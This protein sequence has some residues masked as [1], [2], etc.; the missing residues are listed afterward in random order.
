MDSPPRLLLSLS[1]LR[2]KSVFG[3]NEAQIPKCREGLGLHISGYSMA[4][5]KGAS[6]NR[7]LVA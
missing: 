5:R 1:T 2:R 6:Q 4:G 7:R 3:R